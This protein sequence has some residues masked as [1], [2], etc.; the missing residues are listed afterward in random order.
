MRS[1]WYDA[2]CSRCVSE[3]EVAQ[4]LDINF[5]GSAY[6][7][8]PAEFIQMLIAECCTPPLM[9]GRLVYDPDSLEPRGFEPDPNGPLNLWF[10]IA[11]GGGL[12]DDRTFF[13][14][15]SFGL[16]ADVSFGAGASNSV[17]SIVDM[18]SGRKVAVWRDSRTEPKDFCDES[19][20]LAKWF[21]DAFTIWDASGAPGRSFTMRV[22]ER[23]YPRIYYRKDEERTRSRITDQPG[24]YLNP[25]D[26][27]VLL[28][29]YKDK[30]GE[31]QFIN[32]SEPGMR[33]CLHFVVQPG[34]KVEHSG[35]A[36]S[37][38]PRGAR[39]AHGDETIADA[40]ASR[41]LVMK[42]L[43]SRPVDPE[44]PYMSPAWRLREWEQARQ[45]AGR[46]D[47]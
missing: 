37:Q 25:E 40:L 43:D 33:E 36:S 35:A 4:E 18:T 24:Y 39:E 11:G 45:R 22:L 19:I 14:G 32:P 3:Q 31:R 17:A 9:V 26:R 44:P 28:R 29:E 20:A 16:G 34:G 41:I 38:D 47:W 42:T 15:K 13:K 7:F 23:K 2:E 21:N 6:Q 27:A 10:N 12:L 8:F 46:E 30:L 5:V 1:P